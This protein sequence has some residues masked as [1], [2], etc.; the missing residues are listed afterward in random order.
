M[1][2]KILAVGLISGEDGNRY[3]FEASDVANLES[4]NVE[5]TRAVRWILKEIKCDKKYFHHGQQYYSSK[6]ARGTYSKN[7]QSIHLKFFACYWALFWRELYLYVDCW[8]ALFVSAALM[9]MRSSCGNALSLAGIVLMLIAFITFVVV[10]IFALTFARELAFVVE[11]KFCFELHIWIS[12]LMLIV[13]ILNFRLG[14]L[15]HLSNC[16][17]Y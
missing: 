6:Y 3:A 2:S 14:S 4:R 10:M 11:Q 8:F 9:L 7:T 12:L 15:G 16:N 17:I 13:V 5:N 1:K